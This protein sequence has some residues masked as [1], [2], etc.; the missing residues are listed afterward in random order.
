MSVLLEWGPVGAAVLAE[1]CD[2]LVIVD[3]LSHRRLVADFLALARGVPV[4]HLM[5]NGRRTAHPLTDGV[6]LAPD[7]LL[8]Y[9]AVGPP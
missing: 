9:D 3:V 2:V 4:E 7:G 8:L 1:S 6:R 5:P